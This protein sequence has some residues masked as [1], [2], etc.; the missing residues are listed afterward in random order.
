MNEATSAIRAELEQIERR[1]NVRVLY[2]VESGSRAWGFASPDSDYDVRFVFVR[3]TTDYARLKPLRDVIELPIDTS[4]PN[5]LDINGWD[6]IKA[7]NLFRSS[8]PPLMEWLHSPLVY[9]EHGDLAGALRTLARERY[10]PMRMSYHYLSMA[11]RTYRESLE[12]RAE[13]ALKKYLYALRPLFAISWMEHR[14]TPPPTNFET[15]LAGIPLAH[16]IRSK[17]S[18]LLTRKRS[19]GEAGMGA[20]DALLTAFIETEIERIS[21]HVRELPDPEMAEEPLNTLLWTELG[22]RGTAARKDEREH[23]H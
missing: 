15:T 4:L 18:N 11:T 10:S 22:L 3:P 8:N 12:G 5:P 19:S 9:R 2:A 7:L 1:E 16:E 23:G 6:L 20:K 14:G 13:V 21:A 17:L